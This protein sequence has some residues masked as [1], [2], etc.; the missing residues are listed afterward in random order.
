VSAADDDAG[1]DVAAPSVV[2]AG[3]AVVAVEIVTAYEVGP[4]AGAVEN[5]VAVP[6]EKCVAMIASVVAPVDG[7]FALVVEKFLP[8]YF[9]LICFEPKDLDPV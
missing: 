4:A 8:K 2:F 5:V 7:D 3:F 6:A 9:G 1:G